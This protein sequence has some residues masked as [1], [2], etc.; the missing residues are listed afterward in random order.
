MNYNIL[1]SKSQKFCHKNFYAQTG[2]YILVGKNLRFYT[3]YAKIL[4][5]SK[6]FKKYFSNLKMKK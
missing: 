1:K 4:F 3:V 5:F 2:L 6:I